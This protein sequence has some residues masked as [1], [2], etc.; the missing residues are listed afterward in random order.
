MHRDITDSLL[1]HS[2]TPMGLF[3]MKGEIML[4]HHEPKLYLT[5]NYSINWTKK[6]IVR[7]RSI[8][9]EE[10]RALTWNLSSFHCTDIAVISPHLLSWLL[11]SSCWQTHSSWAHDSGSE[12]LL[13]YFFHNKR[14][15][16]KIDQFRWTVSP[17]GSGCVRSI[18]IRCNQCQPSAADSP[19]P[20]FV[21]L[22]RNQVSAN[23]RQ[24][25]FSCLYWKH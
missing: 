8:C 20:P 21:L 1:Q 15:D 3:P 25:C 6:L 22:Q 17:C 12:C 13:L 14:T 4:H 16:T 9:E 7:G 23:G 5:L 11:I 24:C 10:A 19:P 18:L 2:Q